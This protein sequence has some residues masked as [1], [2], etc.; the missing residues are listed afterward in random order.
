[1][2][3]NI[4]FTENLWNSILLQNLFLLPGSLRRHGG[5]ICIRGS[6]VKTTAEEV[7]HQLIIHETEC[8]TSCLKMLLRTF[9]HRLELLL[10]PQ[11]FKV[12]DSEGVKGAIVIRS[13]QLWGPQQVGARAST[14]SL[15]GD[16]FFK[17]DFFKFFR[18]GAEC[19]HDT[20]LTKSSN[21]KI[22][23]TGQWL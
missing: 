1:M 20:I 21:L 7:M 9:Y 18:P 6:A 19:H 4:F 14:W 17:K 8:D 22:Q 10:W 2:H 3:S 11:E 23:S 12:I 15:R 16:N 13:N 5:C